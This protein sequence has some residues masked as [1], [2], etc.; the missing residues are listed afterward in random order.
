MHYTASDISL[1]GIKCNATN[2]RVAELGEGPPVLCLHGWPGSWYSWRHQV[3][4]LANA[5]YRAI[6]P[7]MPGYGGS[8]R[9]PR[10]SDYNII[11]LVAHIVGLLDALG[12]PECVLVGH[13]W[14]AFI[15]WHVALL[16][17]RR[18]SKLVTLSIPLG[19][20]DKEPPIQR[21]KRQHGKNFTHLLYFQE[22]GVAE[23]EFDSDPYGLL[24]RLYCSPDT[25]RDPPEIVDADRNGGGLIPRLGRPLERPDWLDEKDLDY[26]VGEFSRAGF[27]GG[28][29][30]YRSM[31]RNWALLAPFEDDVIEARVLF[32]AGE[33]ENSEQPITSDRMSSIMK[34]R[35]P[36]LE[37]VVVVPNAGHWLQQEAAALVSQEIISFIGAER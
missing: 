3:L 7:D 6:A 12:E 8:D 37:R 32:L 30:Y 31:D 29:D 13:D 4:D 20:H 28:L 18:V 36:N 34:D 19:A 24:S 9:L 2:W 15:A 23:K 35:V 21:A 26:F 27:K 10:A 1:R 14:G 11:N 22:P 17:R 5:G 16:H 33:R 25:P